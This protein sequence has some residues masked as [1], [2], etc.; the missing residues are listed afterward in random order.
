MRE[1][2]GRPIAPPPTYYY[3]R[4]LALREMLPALGVG[5]GVGVAAFYVARL[6]LQRTSLEP[7]PRASSSPRLTRRAP[8]SSRGA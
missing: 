7:S 6:M 8:A 4:P 1:E 2:G 3:R 5:L